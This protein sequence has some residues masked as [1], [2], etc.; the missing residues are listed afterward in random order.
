MEAIAKNSKLLKVV[1][2]SFTS[3]PPASI[4]LLTLECLEMEVLKLAGVPHMVSGYRYAH[5]IV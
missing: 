3:A 2:L 1:N 5:L 4:A